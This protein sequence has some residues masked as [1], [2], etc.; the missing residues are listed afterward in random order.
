VTRANE[1]LADR[2]WLYQRYVID[3]DPVT[4]IAEDAGSDP[5]SVHRWL[6]RHGI[7]LRGRGSLAGVSNRTVRSTV[8]RSP[9]MR[10][11]A[12]LLGVDARTV[13]ERLC[14]IG[15]RPHADPDGRAT[16]IAERYDSGATLA[17]LAE[18]YAMSVRTVRRRVLAAGRT[19]R[20]AGRPAVQCGP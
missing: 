2:A 6:A 20:P 18:E 11:A 7:A 3:G 17:E 16:T 14:A 4:A 5:S 9:S 13:V 10:D 1:I 19:L 12:R 15:D 8:R